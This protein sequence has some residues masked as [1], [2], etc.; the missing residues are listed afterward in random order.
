MFSATVTSYAQN[1]TDAFQFSQEGIN[2][3]ARFNSMAGAFT[4]LGGDISGVYQ[5]PAG[6]GVYKKSEWS[7]SLGLQNNL[8]DSRFMGTNSLSGK[9]NLNIPTLAFV[10]SSNNL[11]GRWRNGNLAVYLNRSNSFHSKFSYAAD[12]S[13][14]SLLD[15]YM[16]KLAASGTTWEQLNDGANPAYPYDIYLAWQN[17]LIDVDTVNY[18]YYTAIGLKPINQNYSQTTYGAKRETGISYG[19]NYD[20]KLYIGAGLLF[21][22]IV[23][24]KSY[25]FIEST[26]EGDTTTYLDHYI[27]KFDEKTTGLGVGLNL[28]AIYRPTKNI[29]IGAS[30]K[31]PTRYNLRIDYESSNAAYYK[32]TTI[33]TLSPTLGRYDYIFRSPTRANVGVAY[34]FDKYGLIS[35]DGEYIAYNSTRFLHGTDG[36]QFG[37]ENSAIA[38]SLNNTMN[39]RVGAEYR[40]S[41]YWSARAGFAYYT[42]AYK[43]SIDDNSSFQIYSA[44]IGYRDENYFI[45]ASYQY[46]ASQLVHYAYDPSIANRAQIGIQD[47]LIT[48]SA[49]FKF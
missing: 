23:Y 49:G 35:I 21:S 25:S 37:Q 45:D 27:Y 5:N 43:T 15:A 16:N 6:V 30:I 7:M 44:G 12:G 48:L 4:S 17:Y 38:S 13:T 32:D 26:A 1:E 47:H 10:Q 24:Q 42:N 34:L 2:G 20:D 41:S 29:R 28:G 14:T 40:I 19:A 31:S 36:Y 33:S 39:L 3:S 18:D 9:T 8:T 46:K 22:R 11:P